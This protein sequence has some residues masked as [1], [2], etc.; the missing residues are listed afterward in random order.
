M[1][2]PHPSTHVLAGRF[3]VGDFGVTLDRAD[4]VATVELATPAAPQ[5][6][7][8]LDLARA[9][10]AAGWEA[11]DEGLSVRASRRLVSAVLRPPPQE[12]VSR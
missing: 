3:Q 6:T 1:L 7:G 10:A 9:A 2:S 4:G 11:V 5:E 12:P 8:G